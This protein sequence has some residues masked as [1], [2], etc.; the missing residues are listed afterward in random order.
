MK[1]RRMLGC[2]ASVLLSAAC[3][4]DA[5]QVTRLGLRVYYEHGALRYTSQ[6]IDRAALMVRD[7]FGARFDPE[8]VEIVM[9]PDIWEA[10][11]L[12]GITVAGLTWYGINQI[13]VATLG[14]CLSDTSLQ[15]ELLHLTLGPGG[16]YD[17]VTFD[18][19]SLDWTQ[20]L[21]RVITEFRTQV[22]GERE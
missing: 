15:H 2:L 12:G 3:G 21:P 13:E 22:C 10:S 17:V 5:D 8:T 14:P 19:F 6:D 1:A 16:G 7:E 9:R 4:H 11:T 20:R 18:H